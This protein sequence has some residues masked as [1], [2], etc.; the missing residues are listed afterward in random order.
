MLAGPLH[1]NRFPSMFGNRSMIPRSLILG[2]VFIGCA[3][4]VSAQPPRTT[5]ATPD[6]HGESLTRETH[7]STS[8]SCPPFLGC[9]DDYRPKPFPRF[10]QLPCGGPDDYCPKPFPRIWH[11]PC[12]GPDD[13][14]C[15]PM[16]KIDRPL[17]FDYYKCVNQG[18]CEK[19]SPAWARGANASRSDASP[20]LIAPR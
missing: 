13:Y 4:S 20:R 7:A 6:R 18:C 11:L 2:V 12:G 19:C 5:P 17:P 9:P 10:W 8:T 16:P 1:I 3:G 15:K 14:C